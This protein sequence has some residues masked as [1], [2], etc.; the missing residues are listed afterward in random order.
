MRYVLL[1]CIDLMLLK[2]K[3][4]G[5]ESHKTHISS[6]STTRSMCPILYHRG[7]E[8]HIHQIDDIDHIDHIGHI[9][10]V[11]HVQKAIGHRRLLNT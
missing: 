8:R 6:G 5:T 10:T 7:T 11:V 9:D 4:G 2:L 1:E 3:S